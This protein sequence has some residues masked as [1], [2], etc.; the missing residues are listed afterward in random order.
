[1][2]PASTVSALRLSEAS[3]AKVLRAVRFHEPVSRGAIADVT[4]LSHATVGRSVSSLI[5]NGAVRER[6]DLANGGVTGRPVT[7]VELDPT[8]PVVVAFHVGYVRSVVAIGDLASH[9]LA[10]REV[11]TPGGG[12]G[13]VVEELGS[14]AFGLLDAFRGRR[15]VWGGV[16]LAARVARSGR[17]RHHLLGWDDV[18]LADM[19][20]EILGVPFSV[21]PHVEAMAASELLLGHETHEGTTL[22]VYGRESFGLSLVIDG[23]VHLPEAGPADLAAVP[24]GS[25]AGLD[26]RGR[27]VVDT[28]SDTGVLRAAR[29]RGVE[30][31]RVRDLVDSAVEGSAAHEIL[32]AR[33]RALGGLV[34][35]VCA[36]TTPDTVVLAGQAFTDA[37]GYLPVMRAGMEHAARG[38]P[39]PELR[40]TTAGGRVQQRAA[41]AV[42]LDPVSADPDS[43]LA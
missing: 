20:A 24:I 27:G 36:I 31:D 17:I 8:G 14:V 7:P 15:V 33:A 13:D 35:V 21:A 32:S 5:R 18:P 42:A 38:A 30:V 29:A 9:I 1:M 34:A 28:L 19:C 16:T 12:P 25:V 2:S 37:P 6:P 10:Q 11:D 3:S 39:V 40:V 4:G 26:D 22:L 43:V 41:L 23:R